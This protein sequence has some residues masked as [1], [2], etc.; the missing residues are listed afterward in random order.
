MDIIQKS[1]DREAIAKRVW[2]VV[3]ALPHREVIRTEDARIW[4][5]Q[6]VGQHGEAAMWHAIRLNGFG[7][8]EIGVLV[9]NFHGE[10]ADHNMSAHDIVAAK[11][12]K[13]APLEETSHLRRGHE[14]EPLHAQRFWNKWGAVRDEQAFEM[15]SRS[16]G[17][18]PWMRY[19]PD[20]LVRMP[21]KLVMKD[22]QVKLARSSKP[23][24]WLIDYKAPSQVDQEA[25]VA[26][27]YAAQLHQGAI[28]CTEAGMDLDG[29]MLSQFDWAN[30]ALKDDVVQWDPQ[31]GQSLLEAG[32]HYWEFVLRGE[33]PRYIV[34]PLWDQNPEYVESMRDHARLYAALASLS[35][36]AKE[37]ADEVRKQLTQPI[38]DVRLGPA[39][40][41]FIDPDNGG[42]LLSISASKML[43]KDLAQSLFSQEQL[44]SCEKGDKELDTK[45]M[46]RYL[47]EQGVDT[48]QFKKRKLDA[49]KVFALAQQLGMDPQ[50]LVK[51]Q[52]TL[53]IA[54]PVKEAMRNY[55]AEA[56]PAAPVAP[57]SVVDCGDADL[58][59]PGVAQLEL[60]QSGPTDS[61]TQD[62]RE[63]EEG[64]PRMAA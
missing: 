33:L 62:L 58:V 15:L 20:D 7:G 32:D 3:D 22:G 9:R 35:D 64:A 1:E 37:R 54:S 30:W 21:F 31:M 53:R 59:T 57:V 8:S 40:I 19:S 4:I 43:D 10:R 38:A 50:L 23:L 5:D 55:L 11:L 26:F 45:A 13:R 48:S 52:M 42:K 39:K 49:D 34:T 17:R 12:M 63:I 25:K 28:L 24:L 60:V 29:M 6:V 51:E 47:Q 14:N 18:H 36:A 56:Y 44:D 41:D 46:E 2:A 16:K 27:Q 61:A